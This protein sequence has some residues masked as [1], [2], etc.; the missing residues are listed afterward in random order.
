MK[1][2]GVAAAMV[3]LAGCVEDLTAIRLNADGSGT[4]TRTRRLKK[5]AVELAREN[6]V[7]DEFTEEKAKARAEVLGDGVRYVSSKRLEDADWKGMSAVYAFKDIARLKLEE[8]SFH[9]EKQP[10]GRLRLTA[11]MPFTPADKSTSA[12]EALKLTEENKRAL[13]A[14]I[15]MKLTVEVPGRVTACSSPYLEGSTLTLLEFDLD[16][17]VA[18]EARLKKQAALEPST[19]EEARKANE[20]LQLLLTLNG[21]GADDLTAH[22]EALRKIRGFK[23]ALEPQVTLEFAP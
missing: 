22:K 8:K 2:L 1:G 23:H 9:L 13:M 21:G 4:L 15:K 12:P 17:L 5:W 3:L 6:K 7:E 19:L 16:Q 10:D 20:A 14:G 18:E 11:R